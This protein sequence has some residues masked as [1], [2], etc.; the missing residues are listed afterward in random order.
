MHPITGTIDIAKSYGMTEES[1][2]RLLHVLRNHSKQSLA[3]VP[4]F[5]NSVSEGS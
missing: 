1:F 2:N 4:A 3:T 5:S